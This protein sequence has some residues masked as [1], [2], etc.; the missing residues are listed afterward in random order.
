M[1]NFRIKL[2]GTKNSKPFVEVEDSLLGI[3][4]VNRSKLAFV[5]YWELEE[6]NLVSP[7]NISVKE[8]LRKS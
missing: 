2:C 3:L 7:R 6:S 1:Q 5:S 8:K 4:G